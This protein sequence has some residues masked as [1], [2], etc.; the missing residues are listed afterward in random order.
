ML[1]ITIINNRSVEPETEAVLDELAKLDVVKIVQFDEEFNY[2]K[3][4]NM[5]S[6]NTD[7]EY[8]CLV[9]NDVE[10]KE[11]GWLES[12]L[13]ASLYE[14]TGSVGALLKYPSGAIQHIGIYIGKFL[15]ASHPLR[16]K[17]I[18]DLPSGVI[19]VM[20]NTGACLLVSKSNYWSVGGMDESLPVGLNDVDLCVRLSK[21]GLQNRLVTDVEVVHQE[22]LTRGRIRK[23]KEVAS[24]IYANAYVQE[25]HKK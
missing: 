15:H 2:S 4:N 16:G 23:A 11:S 10:F 20:A 24:A 19:D 8:I 13:L 25:K 6:V 21:S 14:G 22:S 17:F 5:A 18:K 9:N 12:M 1:G 3:L 7:A